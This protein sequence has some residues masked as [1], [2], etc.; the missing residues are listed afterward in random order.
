MKRDQILDSTCKNLWLSYDSSKEMLNLLSKINQRS[1]W[2]A[3]EQGRFQLCGLQADLALLLFPLCAKAPQELFSHHSEG[4]MSWANGSGLRQKP[5][6]TRFGLS[7]QK[8]IGICKNKSLAD[9]L[10]NLHVEVGISSV[11]LHNSRYI[12][13]PVQDSL[14]L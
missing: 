9:L 5:W 14:I 6:S 10:T 7:V 8:S 3:W 11:Y 13:L 2:Y 4:F 1:Q 12:F